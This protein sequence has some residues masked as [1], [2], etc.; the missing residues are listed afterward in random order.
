MVTRAIEDVPRNYAMVA[1]RDFEP[2]FS[3]EHDNFIMG[4][5]KPPSCQVFA[6]LSLEIFVPR[7]ALVS[8][9]MLFSCSSGTSTAE[10]RST[11][12]S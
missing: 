1:E 8:L 7:N 2:V 9:I 12:L 6:N 5:A 10:A 4:M 3:G 11:K